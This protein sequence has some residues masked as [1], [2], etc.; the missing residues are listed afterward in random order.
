MKNMISNVYN[1]TIYCT[2]SA[3]EENSKKFIHL[4]SVVSCVFWCKFSGNIR[5]KKTETDK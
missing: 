3:N 4:V 5:E 1:T 2:L